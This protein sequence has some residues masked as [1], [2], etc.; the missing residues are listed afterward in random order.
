MGKILLLRAGALG[1]VL[2]LRRA[3]AALTQ[4]G[5]RSTLLAPAGPASALLGSGPA[6]V[7][8]V[9]PWERAEVADLASEAPELDGPLAGALEDFEAALAYTRNPVLIQS[10][11]QLIAR[12]VPWA[13]QPPPASGH[14]SLWF[15]RATSRLGVPFGQDPPVHTPTS[16]ETQQAAPWLARLP[17]GFLA[18]HPGSGSDRKNWPSGR[19][20]AVIEVLAPSC[21]WLLVEGPADKEA[22]G[23]LRS[24]RSISAR[25]LP[26]RV[27]G[28][29]LAK[30]G[31]YLG[32]DSGVSHLA[33]AWGAP[34]LALFGPT[35]PAVWGPVGPRV[36][37][38]RSPDE[39]MDGLA[40]EAVVA[41][42]K[43]IQCLARPD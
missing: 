15:A 16:E 31:L 2:L 28:A 22:A 39:T 34:T 18:V 33:A 5:H 42:A 7:E 11:G 32:N 43:P 38:L 27:L 41:A 23:R 21:P 25:E 20:A 14:A 3:V 8:A 6:E 17:P 13:P 10:L 26:P 37:N 19:L 24:A 36:S 4:A 9:I 29:V 35:D 40:V 1:D 30:A 12:V